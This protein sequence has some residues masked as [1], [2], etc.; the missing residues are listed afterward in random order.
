[1]NIDHTHPE[2]QSRK[3]NIW[4]FIE[5]ERAGN[6]KRSK[7][8]DLQQGV[9]GWQLRSQQLVTG[10]EKDVLIKTT[11]YPKLEIAYLLST[12]ERTKSYSSLAYR[13]A[14]YLLKLD[15]ELS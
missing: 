13:A 5:T 6:S 11:I 7:D 8:L 10:L 4:I 15:M 12:W 9:A 1:M 2:K 14:V 3:K